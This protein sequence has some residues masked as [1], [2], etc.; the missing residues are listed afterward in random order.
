M[1]PRRRNH[2]RVG[3]VEALPLFEYAMRQQRPTEDLA[4][5][6]GRP[7]FVSTG[8]R[9]IDRALAGG[10]RVGSATLLA[11]RP[12]VGATSLLIGAALAALKRGERVAYLSERHKEPQLRGRFVVLE[13]RVNGYRFQAGFVSAADRL[14]IAAARDRVAW[15]ELTLSTRRPILA[16]DIDEH[17]FSYRPLLVVADV[18]PRASAQP[19]SR[20]IEAL[21]EGA[22]RLA[23]IAQRHHVALVVRHILPMGALPPM[24][25]ELPGNGRLAKAFQAVVLMHREDVK[26]PTGDPNQPVGLAEVQVVRAHG[27]DQHRGSLFLEFDQRFA[28]LLEPK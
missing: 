6:E 25:R 9:S 22:E 28:G 11:A 16:N 1:P 3:L 27:R 15:A 18:Q 24:R 10:F 23:A 14:A 13:S 19:G 8:L 20:R 21:L 2:S 17:L 4:R 7:R 12:R 26:S 5:I